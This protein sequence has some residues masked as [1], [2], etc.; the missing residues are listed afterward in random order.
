MH[1]NR[2]GR[3]KHYTQHSWTL[4]FTV[5]DVGAVLSYRF[6]GDVNSSD[7]GL[8]REVSWSQVLSLGANLRYGLRGTPFCFGVGVQQVPELRTINAIQKDVW[9]VHLTAAFDLPLFNFYRSR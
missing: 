4:D 9:R 1:V 3:I 5:V 2:N 8:P 7:H 6:N